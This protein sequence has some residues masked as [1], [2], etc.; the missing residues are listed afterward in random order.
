MKQSVL[1]AQTMGVLQLRY[2][3]YIHVQWNLGELQGSYCLP[4]PKLVGR[5]KYSQGR[6]LQLSWGG[7]RLEHLAWTLTLILHGTSGRCNLWWF[8]ACQVRLWVHEGLRSWL[9]QG[10]FFLCWLLH[11]IAIRWALGPVLGLLRTFPP[12]NMKRNQRINSN[13]YMYV[14]WSV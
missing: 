11:V 6:E 9:N 7:R 10:W 8:K 14:I 12:G 2:Q 1:T 13:N 5:D 3:H 4:C